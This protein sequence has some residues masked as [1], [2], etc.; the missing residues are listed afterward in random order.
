M[1]RPHI[2]GVR[3]THNGSVADGMEEKLERKN[4]SEDVL[5][6][7]IEPTDFMHQTFI[8]RSICNTQYRI[9]SKEI[10][11]KSRCLR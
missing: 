7:R 6:G 4:A 3:E 5:S 10:K 9:L 8:R 11:G 1:S 2:I